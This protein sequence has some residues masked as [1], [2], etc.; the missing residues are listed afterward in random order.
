MF[1]KL[2]SAAWGNETA[3]EIDNQVLGSMNFIIALSCKLA[4]GDV[5]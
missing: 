5:R 3:A 1:A 2:V 4:A